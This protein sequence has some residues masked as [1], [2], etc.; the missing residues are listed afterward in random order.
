MKLS[1]KQ[2][3]WIDVE[4]QRLHDIIMSPESDVNTKT[5]A[6]WDKTVLYNIIRLHNVEVN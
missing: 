4:S 5:V 1:N 6:A 2:I 3:Q